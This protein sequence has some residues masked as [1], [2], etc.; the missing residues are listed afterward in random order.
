MDNSL[1]FSSCC[2]NFSIPV[3]VNMSFKTRSP[4]IPAWFEP[5]SSR[6]QDIPITR[7][8]I[9]RNNKV[10]Q[11]QCLPIVC[12]SNLRSLW[13]KLNNW[14]NDTLERQISLSL[15]SEIW[16]R[17]GNKKHRNE[18]EKMLQIDGLKYISTP[19]PSS[20]RGGGCAVVAYSPHFSLE[21][22]DIPIPSSV[23]VVY[24][25]LRA[26]N[27]SAK[28]KE[29]ISVAFYS[30]PR[31]RKKN[32]LLDHIVTTCHVLLT[33]Y[34]NA[35][36]FIGGDRNELS[37]SPLLNSI[38]K[39]R[40]INTRNTC[41]GKVLDVLMTN[42]PELY[43]LPEII[44]PVQPDN[45]DVGCPSDHNPVIATPLFNTDAA[46]SSSNEYI[47][48]QSRPLPES[49]VHEFGQWLVGEK[50]GFMDDNYSSTKQAQVFEEKIAQK[51]N[52]MLPQKQFKISN[53][54]KPYITADLKKLDR[55]KK[56]EYRKHGK[57]EKYIQLKEKF[58]LKMKQAVKNHLDKNVRALKES[59]PGKAYT[60]LK[61]M[62]SQPGDYLDDG[63]FSLANHLEENLTKQESV[64]RIA[65]HF[66]K[67]SQEY[68]PFDAMKIPI[69]VN[70]K[71]SPQSKFFGNPPEIDELEVYKKIKSQ[72]NQN[73]GFLV[74][75]QGP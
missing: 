38:P 10:S 17:K 5:Y 27:P 45:P 67:I 57:S 15:L 19:R 12:V 18:I 30:P 71:L 52:S 36:L 25:L 65:S 68:P 62:G 58:N 35:A 31:S 32:Q 55:L 11:S 61:R 53:R 6:I 16:Q 21:K 3:V 44:P 41:N 34:P 2:E 7:K 70:K 4:D 50:W 26:K 49:G 60:T 74:T 66:S 33:K 1:N 28:F 42:I 48:K 13:P 54:D 47:V 64:D 8:T 72:I 59:D 73:L 63:T 22:I 20:K 75:F 37:I 39:L 69:E 23:E 51:L 9:Y 14:K 40:Q 43:S 29:I 56:R 24:G 46:H